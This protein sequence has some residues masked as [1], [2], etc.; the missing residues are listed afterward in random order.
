M[1]RVIPPK[2]VYTGMSSLQSSISMKSGI[3]NHNV[4]EGGDGMNIDSKTPNTRRSSTLLV[5]IKE[6]ISSR[7]DSLFS[8][9]SSNISDTKFDFDDNNE[10]GGDGSLI[11][12]TRQ[13]RERQRRRSTLSYVSD[14][15]SFSDVL[16]NN[17]E[18]AHNDHE[19]KMVGMNIVDEEMADKQNDLDTSILSTS[20][21]RDETMPLIINTN[22][23]ASLAK[24]KPKSAGYDSFGG[25]SSS[26]GTGKQ[27]G[28]LSSTGSYSLAQ[29]KEGF[30]EE[31]RQLS[32]LRHPC[33][34]TVMGAVISTREDPLLIME[35]MDH[36]EQ[37][38]LCISHL[39]IPSCDLMSLFW[40]S[41]FQRF[42]V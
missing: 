13:T 38:F 11:L 9:A 27:S 24:E 17:G 31:M 7:R 5:S 35:Y 15:N 25:G 37:W 6:Y 20:S 41:F 36:G 16:A 23:R 33:I 12:T 32:K 29:L 28:K 26:I 21:S 8:S 40:F 18:G 34:T 22:R 39:L 2:K 42:T 14:D 10:R 1:K 3:A 19:G 30:I 4:K